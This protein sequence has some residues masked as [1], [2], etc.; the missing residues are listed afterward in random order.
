MSTG[1]QD[2][3]PAMTGS[4]RFQDELLNILKEQTQ[5]TRAM[6]DILGKVSKSIE[7]LEAHATAGEPANCSV[8]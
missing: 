4:R 1:E 8:D 7:V 2:T 6:N 3:S 5:Q